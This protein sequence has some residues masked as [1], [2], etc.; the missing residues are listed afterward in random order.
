MPVKIKGS[1]LLLLKHK[2]KSHHIPVGFQEILKTIVQQTRS[3]RSVLMRLGVVTQWTLK[4]AKPR[5][6]SQGNRSDDKKD[7]MMAVAMILRTIRTA[8]L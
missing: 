2:G 4:V 6:K 8:S 3:I 7:M 5:C 1:Q